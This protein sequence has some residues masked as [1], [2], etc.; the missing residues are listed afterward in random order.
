MRKLGTGLGVIVV[1]ALLA[2]SAANAGSASIPEGTIQGKVVDRTCYGPCVIGEKPPLFNGEAIVKLRSLPD[3][4]LVGQAKVEKGRFTLLAPPGT[5]RVKVI[6][7]PKSEVGPYR[8]WQGS[9]RR[10]Q[11]AASETVR[12]RLAVENVCVA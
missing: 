4:Q 1:L 2:A 9:H 8:C 6:P 7:Y 11:I 10:V 12:V 5:Y 3:R